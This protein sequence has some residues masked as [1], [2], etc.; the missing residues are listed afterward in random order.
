M[1]LK[2]VKEGRGTGGIIMNNR[3][4][5]FDQSELYAYMEILP[6]KPFVP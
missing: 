4:D 6:Q 2:T 3:G 1:P 5:G